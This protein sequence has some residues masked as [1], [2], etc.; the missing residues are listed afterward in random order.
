[1]SPKQWTVKALATNELEIHVDRDVLILTRTPGEGVA[2]ELN[3][4][5][6]EMP[7]AM[8]AFVAAFLSAPYLDDELLGRIDRHVGRSVNP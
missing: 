1:M 5:G 7:E 3:G 4:Q 8:T 6:V 2:L